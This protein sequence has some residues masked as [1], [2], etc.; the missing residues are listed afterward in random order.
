MLLSVIYHRPADALDADHLMKSP[1]VARFDPKRKTVLKFMDRH[2][3]MGFVEYVRSDNGKK[4]WRLLNPTWAD[5]FIRGDASKPWLKVP[6]N[7][8]MPSF[9]VQ[10]RHRVT[11]DVHLS[12]SDLGILERLGQFADNARTGGQYTLKT[13]QFSISV[14]AR[15]GN[16]QAWL[17]Q[18]WD[19]GVL[20][21]FSPELHQ[22]LAAQVSAKEGHEH[23]S[24]PVEFLN[25]RIKVG[26]SDVVI[27]GSHY[28]LELDIQGP[29]KDMAKTR[30][31]QLLTD[32]IGF[33]RMMLGI[34]ESLD[35]LQTGQQFTSQSLLKLGE[36]MGKLVEGQTQANTLLKSLVDNLNGNL[37]PKEPEPPYQPKQPD[38]QDYI[39]G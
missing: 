27:A 11:Y 28:P 9:K 12:D 38:K 35:H 14:N 33:N 22:D 24:V 20:K 34:E 32:Q 15:T 10:D 6:P 37:K 39:Y 19:A 21:T 16:G 3:A 13:K 1:G 23:I 31:V 8:A 4:G 26:G 17:F 36:L 25:H 30:A 5:A 18:G 2:V 29:E 7:P